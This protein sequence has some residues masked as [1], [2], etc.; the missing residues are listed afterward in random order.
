MEPNAVAQRFSIG[1]T[2]KDSVK[3]FIRNLILFGAIA[4][5]VRALLLLLPKGPDVSTLLAGG[6]I[7]WWRQ[8]LARLR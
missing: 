5:M 7:D 3:I 8:L 4:I 6:A 1:R 2:L